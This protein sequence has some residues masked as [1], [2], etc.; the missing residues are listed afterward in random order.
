MLFPRMDYVNEVFFCARCAEMEHAGLHRRSLSLSIPGKPSPM[1]F[2]FY[3]PPGHMLHGLSLVLMC[4]NC[5]CTVYG[6]C[7]VN[8]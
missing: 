5:D 3:L 1:H 8:F 4:M 7:D 6:R 2:S